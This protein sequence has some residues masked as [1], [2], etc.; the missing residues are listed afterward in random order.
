MGWVGWN[1]CGVV[2]TVVI[3]SNLTAVEVVLSCIEVV[4]MV[5]TMMILVAIVEGWEKDHNLPKG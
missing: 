2:S 4:V 3:A 5:L 1:G